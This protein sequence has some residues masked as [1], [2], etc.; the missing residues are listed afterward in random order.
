[1]ITKDNSQC[2]Q[3]I[4]GNNKVV[5]ENVTWNMEMA[6]DIRKRKN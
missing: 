2:N 1:M 3:I 4:V 5:G 6:K